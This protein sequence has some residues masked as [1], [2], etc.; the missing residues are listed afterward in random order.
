[1][2]L[3]YSCYLAVTMNEAILMLWKNLVSRRM[4]FEKEVISAF[5]LILKCLAYF[6]FCPQGKT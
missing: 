4:K 1:M 3:Q 2:P 6:V 5:H